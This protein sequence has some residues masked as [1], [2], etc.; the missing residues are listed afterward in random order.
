MR[1]TR[2][3]GILQRGQHDTYVGGG[4]QREEFGAFLSVLCVSAVN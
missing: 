4:K 2:G 3:A 1:G